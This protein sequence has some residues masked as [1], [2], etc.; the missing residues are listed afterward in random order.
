MWQGCFVWRRG[1]LTRELRYAAEPPTVI[2]TAD[3]LN[4]MVACI[5]SR[6]LDGRLCTVYAITAPAYHGGEA[7][8]AKK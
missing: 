8:K 3:M 1:G 7:R 5:L 4:E 2:T 6:M